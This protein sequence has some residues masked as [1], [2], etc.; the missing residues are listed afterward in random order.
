MVRDL[1]E[2]DKCAKKLV[3]VEDNLNLCELKT[4]QL[5]SLL[6]IADS[7]E[8]LYKQNIE[9]YQSIIGVKDTQIDKLKK[10]R[11]MITLGGV[12]TIILTLIL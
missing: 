10:S 2:G 4:Q 7:K 6:S 1:E 12:I 5:D 3:L 8:Q 9:S 11:K